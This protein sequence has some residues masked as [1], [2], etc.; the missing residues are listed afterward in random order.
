MIKNKET[1]HLIIYLLITF[2]FGYIPCEALPPL[3]MKI[4]GAFLGLI[5]G[6]S[7]IDYTIPSIVSIIALGF[8]GYSTPADVLASAFGNEVCI[9]LFLVLVFSAYCEMSGLSK[10]MAYWFLSR[11]FTFRRPWLFAFIVLWGSFFIGFA[12]T[13]V[14]AAMIIFG[15]LATVFTEMGFKP[16]DKYPAYITFGVAFAGVT[17]YSARAWDGIP[18]IAN[19][20]LQSVSGGTAGGFSFFSFTICAFIVYT[21]CMALYVIAVRFL[22]RPDVSPVLNTSPEYIENLRKDLSLSKEEKLAGIMLIIFIVMMFLPSIFPN[23]A[24]LSKCTMNIVMLAILGILC[25]IKVDEK[26]IFDYQRAAR[27][28]L[29]WGILWM[30]LAV[31]PMTAALSLDEA[32]I[33]PLIS[34]YVG[35][36]FDNFSSTVFLVAFATICIIFTQIARNGVVVAMAVPIAYPICLQFG[37]DTVAMAALAA[38]AAGTAIATPAASGAAA[39]GFAQEKW[40]GGPNAFKCGF[41]AFLI[42]LIC[43]VVIGIPVCSLIMGL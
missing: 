20:A 24:F 31:M 40:V 17:S 12:I 6:W 36:L 43:I 28:G 5:Y 30:C 9:F 3:G 7:S 41:L 39:L 8:A 22:F 16:G 37:I 4:L 27:N 34:G 14:A 1:I 21:A 2:G 19:G 25:M 23:N 11:R 29:N 15:L 42:G 26:H 38:Y 10:K 33:I 13:G 32:G 18:L 35:G